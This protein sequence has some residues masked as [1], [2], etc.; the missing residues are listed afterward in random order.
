MKNKGLLICFTGIDGSGKTTLAKSLEASLKDS[1]KSCKYFW[2]GWR[3]F[4]TPLFKSIVMMTK[5]LAKNKKIIIRQPSSNNFLF[6]VAW[7]DYFVR[8]FPNLLV[9]L[10]RYDVVIVDRYIY[11]II[12]G[13]SMNAK[14]SRG[15]MNNTTEFFSLFPKPSIIFF[16]DLP[17]ELA[18]ARKDDIPSVNYLSQR[19]TMYLELLKNYQNKTI[20]LDGIKS[21]KELTDTIFEIV[22]GVVK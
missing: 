15:E 16:I 12:I 8:V 11:D 19:K 9:S 4:E 3:K 1:R 14:S 2:C 17:I 7:L 13:F 10:Y 5:N 6:Y 18:Y 21:K 20:V 22:M